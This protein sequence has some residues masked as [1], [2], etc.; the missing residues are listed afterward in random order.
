MTL[1]QYDAQ[2]YYAS[3]SEFSNPG[4]YENA[5][6]IFSDDMATLCRQVNHLFLHFADTEILSCSLDENRYHEFNLRY[7]DEILKKM[8]QRDASPLNEPRLL[9]NRVLGICRDVALF[10][11]SILRSRNIPA[12]LRSGF[13]NYYIPNLFLDGFFLEYFDKKAERWK[14]ADVRTSEKHIAHYKLNIDFDLMDVP[15]NHFISV[16]Q[17]WVLAR[18]HQVDPSRFGSRF[19]KGIIFLRNRLIQALALANKKETLAWDIWGEM[20]NLGERDDSLLDELSKLLI[21]NS[22]DIQKICAFYDENANFHLTQRVWLDN[23]FMPGKW[24]LLR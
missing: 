19:S 13:A 4:K 21:E 24:V 14:I 16:E 22:K 2:F 15:P 5:L 11:C 12:Q 18:T 10:C 23:P 3:H 8:F 7:M 1:D 9:E 6:S 17:A 20:L